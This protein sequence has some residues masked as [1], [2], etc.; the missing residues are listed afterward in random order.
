MTTSTCARLG[1]GPVGLVVLL[2]LVGGAFAA[3]E[4]EGAEAT[5][6]ERYEAHVSA[7]PSPTA[8]DAF[9]FE[10]EL[11]LNGE[12]RGRSVFEARLA[13]T[14][15]DEAD[16]DD[17]GAWRVR[18]DLVF[19]GP[20]G[21]TVR[22]E[23]WAELGPDL[24]P[25]RGTGRPSRAGQARTH[26]WERTPGGLR[27]ETTTKPLVNDASTGP[28]ELA[29]PGSL[30]TTLT[31]VILFA[32]SILDHEGVVYET[33]MWDPLETEQANALLPLRL[34]SR[35]KTR[36]RGEDAWVVVGSR[37]R[38][39]LRFAFDP[40]TRAFVGATVD[41][42]N[43]MEIA[44]L[45]PG[46]GR[47]P[48]PG[49]VVEKTAAATHLAGQ[50]ELGKAVDAF[51]EALAIV[52]DYVP[53]LLGRARAWY[54]QQEFEEA[55]KDLDR[56][57]ALAPTDPAPYELLGLIGERT[58]DADAAI[59]AY[60]RVIELD[61]D[62]PH[63]PEMIAR[64]GH[65]RLAAG[66]LAGAEEDYDRA[67]ELNPDL[68][69]LWRG[70][71]I[72]RE[73]AGKLAE[74]IQDFE[75]ACALDPTSPQDWFNLGLT[76]MRA[77]QPARAEAA[78]TAALGRGRAHPIPHLRRAVARLRSGDEAGWLA[79]VFAAARLAPKEPVEVWPPSARTDLAY[80][81]ALAAEGAGPVATRRLQALRM[82]PGADVDTQ[83]WALVWE[84]VAYLGRDGVNP[85]ST[86]MRDLVRRVASEAAPRWPVE[87]LRFLVGDSKAPELRRLAGAA[88]SA[89]ARNVRKA[90]TLFA[91]GARALQRGETETAKELL[92]SALASNAETTP[93]WFAAGILLGR[94]DTTEEAPLPE[95]D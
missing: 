88:E 43:D 81:A 9:L 59:T 5:A 73:R 49:A 70:R 12:R 64:R 90:E 66:D 62:G 16:A 39:A 85:A 71:G 47:D 37:G 79:D 84:W 2:F 6:G 38:Q 61:P 28:V 46:S 10:G 68:P 78:F 76:L 26:I 18:D 77:E 27:I 8:E 69:A 93:A 53:A 86:D 21:P 60:G 44:F 63:I 67:L 24:A 51:T 23:A 15:R 41:A 32:R 65:A 25:L 83:A 42:G 50:G 58:G 94:L 87:L 29:H 57:V 20:Q 22:L 35:G 4:D 82:A 80:A 74:A 36:F 40:T 17:V 72:V 95:A 14:T 31:G 13:D 11:V 33:T 7:L 54:Y 75:K 34:S 30:I 56:I 3:P 1:R 52:D 92:A 55:R 19:E 45:P 48:V 91:E 89:A